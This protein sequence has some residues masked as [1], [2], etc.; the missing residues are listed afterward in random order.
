VYRQFSLHRNVG[1]G[2]HDVA[3]VIVAKLDFS[4]ELP[5]TRRASEPPPER[6]R[7]PANAQ[8]LLITLPEGSPTDEYEF[9]IR[10]EEGQVKPARVLRGNASLQP[11]GSIML[12]VLLSSR[13]PGGT[14][15][16]GWR[17]S[18]DQ[19]W[20]SGAFVSLP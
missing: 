1:P 3:P 16:A 8:E 14:Y 10:P 4:R 19:L 13:L 18:G 17:H 15:A 9:Q 7:I 20:H 5:E 2:Q 12:R 11:D 6:Q